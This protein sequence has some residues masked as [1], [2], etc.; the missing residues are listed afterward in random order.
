MAFQIVSVQKDLVST[1]VRIQFTKFVFWILL[2]RFVF[3]L[4]ALYFEDG[5]T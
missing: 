1:I 2:F 3:S 4:F 5:K